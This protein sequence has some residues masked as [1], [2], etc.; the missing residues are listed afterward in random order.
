MVVDVSHRFFRSY[1][2]IFRLSSKAL[3]EYVVVVV[4][5]VVV[6]DVVVVAPTRI[7]ANGFK[8]INIFMHK[9]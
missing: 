9:Q 7:S 5:V 1:I 6:V 3:G 8:Q 4:V 2:L